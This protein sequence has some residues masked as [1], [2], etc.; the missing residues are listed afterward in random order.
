MILSLAVALA[1][2][3]VRPP[4]IGSRPSSR[5]WGCQRWS[6]GARYRQDRRTP[7]AFNH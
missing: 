5:I 4:S 7:T 6:F 3:F 2:E 1:P